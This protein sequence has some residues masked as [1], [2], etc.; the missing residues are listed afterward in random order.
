M[1]GV[2]HER[3]AAYLRRTRAAA[4][5][6]CKDLEAF[7]LTLATTFVRQLLP[8]FDLKRI[9]PL[10]LQIG[11]CD[12][13]LYDLISAL[14]VLVLSILEV[15]PDLRTSTYAITHNKTVALLSKDGKLSYAI[16]Y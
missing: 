8:G 1:K 7:S 10:C 9:R 4:L 11:E 5:F 6:E 15:F 3:C 16:D 13:R 14:A 12:H 2:K